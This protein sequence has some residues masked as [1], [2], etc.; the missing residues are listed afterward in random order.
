MPVMAKI[1]VIIL[2]IAGMVG[3]TQLPSKAHQEVTLEGIAQLINNRQPRAQDQLEE[4]AQ[5]CGQQ[6]GVQL[7][8]QSQQLE[9]L[10]K[11]LQTLNNATPSFANSMC[12]P[13]KAAAQYEGKMVVGSVEWVYIL[14]PRHHYKARV[15]SGATTS[16]IHAKNIVRFERNGKKWVSFELQDDEKNGTQKLEA[17]LVRNVAIRQAAADEL[18]HRPVVKLTIVLGNM[19]HE[20]DFTLTDRTQMDFSVLLGRTFLQDIALI[21]V[22]RAMIQP[23]FEPN[24]PDVKA[25]EESQQ[26]VENTQPEVDKTTEPKKIITTTEEA[27]APQPKPTQQPKPEQENANVPAK[28]AASE[29]PSA[30]IEP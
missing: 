30:T 6:L 26:T 1:V 7:E 21:D 11:Q 10:T 18:E 5:V 25:V 28:P 9:A 13:V 27:S 2:A 29:L 3:C 23:K 22:G 16:S 15:D 17:P 4:I 12:P 24:L 20:S 19:Q 14:Q 8:G